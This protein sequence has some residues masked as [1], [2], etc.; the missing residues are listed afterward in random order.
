MGNLTFYLLLFV[1][2]QR[3]ICQL[4]EWI[5]GVEGSGKTFY[6]ANIVFDIIMTPIVVLCVDL[7]WFWCVIL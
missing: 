6:D 2:P 1:L 4:T 5:G 3:V 7:T